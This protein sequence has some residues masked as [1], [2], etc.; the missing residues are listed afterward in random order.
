[1]DLKGLRRARLL[2]EVL[3]FAERCLS[4]DEM[5]RFK[6]LV[7]RRAHLDRT[8]RRHLNRKF[9]IPA[10]DPTNAPQIPNF[11]GLRI[12]TSEGAVKLNLIAEQVS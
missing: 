11:D 12:M 7:I 4:K 1:M 8:S 3:Q 9:P 5:N 2:P 10:F 6:L